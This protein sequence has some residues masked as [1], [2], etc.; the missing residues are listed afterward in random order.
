MKKFC[1]ALNNFL[2][3]L[4][5]FTMFLISIFIF[6][7]MVYYTMLWMEDN[8]GTKV[9]IDEVITNTEVVEVKEENNNVQTVNP[10]TNTNV[11]DDYWYYINELG[12]KYLELILIIQLFKLLIMIITLLILLII[13]ITK[14]DGFSWIIVMML[15]LIIKII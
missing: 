1:I 12:Y 2:D 4:L 13:V 3:R 5:N 14:L 9:V 7:F 10:T 11:Q 15:V 8:N 6:A